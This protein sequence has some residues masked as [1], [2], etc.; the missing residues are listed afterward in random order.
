MKHLKNMQNDS[1]GTINNDNQMNTHNTPSDQGK[2]QHDPTKKT[3]EES[4]R[5]PELPEMPQSE[6]PLSNDEAIEESQKEPS[7]ENSESDDEE[8][9]VSDSNGESIDDGEE[10]VPHAL[11]KAQSSK[12]DIPDHLVE[13]KNSEFPYSK[14]P[15]S[16]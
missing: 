7:E 8:E 3:L 12:H 13:L 6:H 9:A 1:K 14:L 11:T 2:V 15:K 4:N 16:K 10:S 5:K